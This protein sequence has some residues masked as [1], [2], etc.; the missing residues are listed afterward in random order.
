MQK[1]TEEQFER[2]KEKSKEALE[3]AYVPLTGAKFGAAVLTFQNNIYSGSNVQSVIS[4][5]GTCA[6]RNAIE[7]AVTHGEY[8][9]KAI[10]IFTSKTKPVKPCGACLQLI[11]EFAEVSQ[12]NIQVIMI[13]QNG[14]VEKSDIHT[15]LPEAYGPEEADLELEEYRK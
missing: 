1:I 10:M 9:F 2:L 8:C 7:N 15:M 11:S 14:D 3:N 5:M 13:G 4:G 12:E 6:E